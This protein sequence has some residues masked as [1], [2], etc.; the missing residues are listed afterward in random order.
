MKFVQTKKTKKIVIEWASRLALIFVSILLCMWM[1]SGARAAQIKDINVSDLGAE[2]LQVSF[3][4]SEPIAESSVALT[5]ERNFVQV[6]LQ[7]ASVYPAKTKSI[8]QGAI[9]KVF[10]YQYQPDVARARILLDRLASK[11][12]AKVNWK[13]E[14]NQLKVN[15]PSIAGVSGGTSSAKPLSGKSTQDAVIESKHLDIE[16]EKVV[17]ELLQTSKSG[18]DK[19]GTQ[20]LNKLSAVPVSSVLKSTENQPVF[21][22]SSVH[23][24]LPENSG[25]SSSPARVIG[26]LLMVIGIFGALAFTSKKFFAGKGL[27][28]TGKGNK[29]IELLVNQSIAPKRSIAIVKV[30]DQYLVIGMSGDNMTLLNN[31]GNDPKIEKMLDEFNGDVSFNKTLEKSFFISDDQ[32]PPK[33]DE[34]APQKVGIR[35][36]IKR[37]LEG[38]KPL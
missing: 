34:P 15:F 20:T 33:T 1:I 36:S 24:V 13:I 2:T 23:A 26:S 28:F 9:D 22:Q 32:A 31:L 37:R 6:S 7:G 35:N 38:F 25:K 8:K 30:L 29:A 18:L 16:D 10:T 4:L 19:S 12:S 21:S 11:V 17:Q 5:F 14:G 3:E 27:S